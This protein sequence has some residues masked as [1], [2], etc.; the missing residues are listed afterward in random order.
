MVIIPQNRPLIFCK[1]RL[2]LIG[3]YGGGLMDLYNPIVETTISVVVVIAAAFVVIDLYKNPRWENSWLNP[4][5][6]QDTD[7]YPND[8]NLSN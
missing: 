2:I 4:K 1:K 7:P 6:G 5:K 3:F 8:R